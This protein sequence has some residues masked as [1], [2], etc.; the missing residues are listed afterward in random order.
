MQTLRLFLFLLVF[1]TLVHAH[2]FPVK[3]WSKDMDSCKDELRLFLM[4]AEAIGI[5]LTGTCQS[6]T[7]LSDSRKEAKAMAFLLTTRDE[8]IGERSFEPFETSNEMVNYRVPVQKEKK[9]LMIGENDEIQ[10][11]L[12]I[13]EDKEPIEA[14]INLSL[15]Y[16][17]TDVENKENPMLFKSYIRQNYADQKKIDS[18]DLEYLPV[19]LMQQCR[20][21]D[22]N[23]PGNLEDKAVL[24]GYIY[25]KYIPKNK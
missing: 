14:K 10:E 13:V 5:K 15:K 3:A 18:N 21:K 16:C 24:F 23:G 12:I 22:P 8:H 2:D 1:T 25:W 11:A 19:P 20:K 4:Q 6:Y 9:V 7:P 17:Y